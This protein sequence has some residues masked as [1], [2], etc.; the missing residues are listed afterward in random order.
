MSLRSPTGGTGWSE[1]GKFTGETKPEF[2]G[3][4]L[5]MGVPL[6]SHTQLVD[7]G[8]PYPTTS[9][10]AELFL[11]P[12]AVSAAVSTT[13]QL[14]PDSGITAAAAA[15]TAFRSSAA[16]SATGLG[17]TVPTDPVALAEA[18]A[19]ASVALTKTTIDPSEPQ[20][21]PVVVTTVVDGDPGPKSAAR[22]VAQNAAFCDALQE[23]AGD[24]QPG[25]AV[26]WIKT[27]TTGDPEC[28]ETRICNV[29]TTGVA[30]WFHDAIQSKPAERMY[31]TTTLHRRTVLRLIVLRSVHALLDRNPQ[32]ADPAWLQVRSAELGE[33]L[34]RH[35]GPSKRH[36]NFLAQSYI[37]LHQLNAAL[38][39]PTAQAKASCP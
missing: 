8:S 9:R 35:Y 10:L 6:L 28:V 7:H 20:L 39:N 36:P 19:E 31:R 22:P 5:K 34:R 3:E 27:V 16:L 37:D 17:P 38:G 4:L 24:P 12:W 13:L 14:P 32:P 15:A 26:R 25:S 29:R 23:L 2:I 30:H 1:K 18:L 33:L 11:H 21:E